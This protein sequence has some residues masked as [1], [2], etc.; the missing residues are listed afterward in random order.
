MTFAEMIAYLKDVAATIARN[1]VGEIAVA[2][3]GI[4][5]VKKPRTRT[6]AG[7]KKASTTKRAVARKRPASRTKRSGA[8]M[9]RR[10]SR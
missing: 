5:A 8:A 4:D 6:L 2:V 1:S 7:Y 3:I 10:R 9:K